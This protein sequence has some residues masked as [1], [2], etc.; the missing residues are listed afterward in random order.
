M[1]VSLQHLKTQAWPSFPFSKIKQA[2]KGLLSLLVYAEMEI[3]DA[4]PGEY[5]TR[6]AAENSGRAKSAVAAAIVVT[7]FIEAL[8]RQIDARM[9]VRLAL[10]FDHRDISEVCASRAAKSP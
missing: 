10:E 8:N 4:S 3:A 5:N 1:R 6:P 9:A 7:E 2:A